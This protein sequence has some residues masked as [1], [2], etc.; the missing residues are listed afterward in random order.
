MR[1]VRLI[2]WKAEEA[3]DR[4]AQLE[5]AG[6]EVDYE[7]LTF[8]LLRIIRDHPPAAVV[9]DL[10][11]M[12]SHGREVAF[13]LRDGKKTRHIPLVFIGGEPD[14]VEKLRAALPDATYTDWERFRSPLK[15]A[16]ASPPVSPVTPPTMMDRYANTPLVKKLGIRPNFSVAVLRAPDDFEHT[17]GD[18]PAGVV[19]NEGMRGACDL[20]LW[21]VRSSRDLESGIGRMSESA[22][23]GG[24]WIIYPK[25]ASG[26]STD[27]TQQLVR[28]TG[29]A[30]GLVDFKV[31]AVDKTWTGLKFCRRREKK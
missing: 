20:A 31:C 28:E 30:H 23:A 24:V 6:Y 22:P 5:S 12:P 14:K 19:F 26:M 2:H 13:T 16:I 15:K 27:L 25:Q 7:A 18:L 17:L 3:R 4:I 9:I 11:R 8:G 10:T 1:R 29:L 21:F